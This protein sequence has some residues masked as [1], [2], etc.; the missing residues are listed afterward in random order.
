MRCSFNRREQKKE[1]TVDEVLKLFC[2]TWIN[3]DYSRDMGR[4]IV[5]HPDG[6]MSLYG[7]VELSSDTPHRKERYTID[8]AWTDKDGNIWFKTTSKMPDGTTH[9]LNK[10]NKSGTVWEYHWAFIDSDLPDGINPDAPKYRIRHR[11]TE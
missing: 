7:L 10:I 4:K 9:Q 11:K 8:E 5:V 3:P 2:H 6:T 1:I